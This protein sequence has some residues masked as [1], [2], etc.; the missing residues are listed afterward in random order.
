MNFYQEA[1]TLQKNT[2][3]LLR[4]LIQERMGLY[5]EENRADVLADK[6][7]PL[8]IEKG[9]ASFLDTTTF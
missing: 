7:S 3:C 2:F 8:V 9:F 4:N 5:F 1:L 6:L